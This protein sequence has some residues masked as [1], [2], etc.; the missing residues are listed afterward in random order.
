[1]D[2]TTRNCEGFVGY[3]YKEVAVSRDMEGV[4]ADG[5]PHFGW[6]LDRSESTAIGLST[7]FLK[8]K[9]DRKIR[10]KAE[11]TRLQRQFESNVREIEKLEQ[12]KTTTASIAAFTIGLIG[13]AFMTGSVFAFLADMIPLF[14][15]LAIPAL[16]GWALPYFSFTRLTAKR[17]EAV[18]PLIDQQYDAIH[19]VCEKAH[20]LLA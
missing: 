6:T 4:Y 3:E 1:M 2:E 11:L 16:V 12:S 7:T 10:N 9:R 8:F 19:E 17:A 5:Y 15:V 13:T 18:L 14:I 20:C